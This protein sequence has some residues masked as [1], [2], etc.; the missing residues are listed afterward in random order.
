VTT[1]T[2]FL[3]CG[4]QSTTRRRFSPTTPLIAGAA[5]MTPSSEPCSVIHFAAVFGPTLSTPGMLSTESPISAS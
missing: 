5:A 3:P 4:S 2:S 1:V